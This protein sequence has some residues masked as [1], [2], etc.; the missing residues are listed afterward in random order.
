MKKGFIP[1]NKFATKDN[2]VESYVCFKKFIDF[3]E[4]KVK[5][6]KSIRAHFY[7]FVLDKIKQIPKLVGGI[8]PEEAQQYDEIL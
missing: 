1:L 7:R 5:N 6:D 3:L 4:D 2:T 8:S